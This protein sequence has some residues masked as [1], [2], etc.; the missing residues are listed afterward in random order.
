[1]S[2]SCISSS[3][4]A[5]QAHLSEY[6]CINRTKVLF[7]LAP[8]GLQN[9]PVRLRCKKKQLAPSD[10]ALMRKNTLNHTQTKTAAPAAIPFWV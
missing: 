7:V 9:S 6:A 5:D 3:L 10:D 1:M 2:F 4:Q 8:P